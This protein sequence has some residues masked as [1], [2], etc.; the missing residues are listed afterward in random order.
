MLET[1]LY[2]SNSLVK[3]NKRLL[4]LRILSRDDLT[5]PPVKT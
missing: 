5:S 1:K 4:P 2:N 3:R